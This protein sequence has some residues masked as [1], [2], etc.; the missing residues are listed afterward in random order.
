MKDDPSGWRGEL[1]DTRASAGSQA[2]MRTGAISPT[3]ACFRSLP[4]SSTVRNP[5]FSSPAVGAGAADGCPVA[6]PGGKPA[7]VWAAEGGKAAYRGVREALEDDLNTPEALA[8]LSGIASAANTAADQGDT[9]MMAATRADLLAAGE[10]LGLLA[11]SPKQWEQGG[12]A[13]DAARIDGLVAARV[14]ARASKDWAEADRIRKAL[15]EEGVEIMDGAGGSTW[16]R[17]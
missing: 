5:R 6:V 14:A 13:D 2:L 11:V 12:N 4:A 16:R 9:A 8:E 3:Q 17:I 1:S 15:A 10:L 7:G